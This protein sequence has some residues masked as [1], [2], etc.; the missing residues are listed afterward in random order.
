ML[1]YARGNARDTLG[2]DDLRKGLFETL[3]RLG[4]TDYSTPFVGADA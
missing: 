4:P 3:D 2:E 1:Y